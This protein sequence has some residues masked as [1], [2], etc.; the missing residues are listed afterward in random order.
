[1]E[2]LLKE[3]YEK[4]FCQKAVNGLIPQQVWVNYQNSMARLIESTMLMAKKP[5]MPA[6]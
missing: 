4:K 3:K 6:N 1:M 2:V 5:R